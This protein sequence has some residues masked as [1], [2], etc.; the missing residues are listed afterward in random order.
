MSLQALFPELSATVPLTEGGSLSTST[1]F[2]VLALTLDAAGLSGTVA[3]LSDFTLF[4][5]TDDA[6]ANLA[7]STGFTGDTSDATAVFNSIAGTLASLDPDGDPIPLLT[8]ILLYH[9]SPDSTPLADLSGAGEVDT[10][11]DGEGFQVTDVTVVDA[12]PD[13]TNADIVAP[14]IATNAGTVQVV[15]QVLLPIDTPV[16][17][18]DP[19]LLNLLEES[20]G[21]PDADATDFD[22]LLTALQA[23]GLD[24]VVDD[25]EAEL[26]VF[27]PNDGAFVSLAQDLGYAGEDEGEALQTILDASAA[28]DPENPLQLVTDI[29]TYHVS[30]GAQ[31]AEAVLASETLA[32]VNGETI[33]VEGTTLV[34]QDADNADPTL[35]DTDIAASNGIAHAIDEVL[36]PVDIPEVDDVRPTDEEVVVDD[37]DGGFGEALVAVGL[38]GLVA[39]LFGGIG[40]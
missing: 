38:L 3:G 11:F 1:D 40:V 37:D 18:A 24:A 33:G 17:D 28:A 2:E 29:L 9:V 30:P 35:I 6:F 12:D 4:A 22:L 8:D 14:D 21:A 16:D 25:E 36:L 15:D 5:P 26:T 13:A 20:G 23:T 7:V 32:T 10:L 34:D 31:D 27:L 39:L 19:T